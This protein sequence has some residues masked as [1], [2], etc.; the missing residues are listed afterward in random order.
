MLTIDK[1]LTE[2]VERGGS[3]LHIR[4]DSH[5]LV[6]I[7]G[8]LV[9]MEDVV[10]LSAGEAKKLCYSAVAEPL[11][12]RFEEEWEL[13]FAYSI[14]GVARFR[15]NLFVQ[16]G[17]VQSVFRVIPLRIQTLEE[18][19]LPPVC[20][21]FAERPRGLVLV[22]GPA[23]SGKSTTQAAMIDYI[24]DNFP[25]H[26]VTIEDPVEFIHEDREALINQRELDTDTRSFK[27]AL[28]A[29]LRQDPDV[30]LVGEM[31][32]L[33]TIQL[34]ITAA[35]TGH[36]VFGTLHTTDAVQ[37]I[38]RVIDVFPMH[39][40]QQIRM[41][42]SVN[43]VGVISQTLIK[44]REGNSRVAAFEILVGVPA[45]RNLIRESKTYQLGS[46]VQ[47]G[48]KQ[49]MMTLDQS[50]ATL[51]RNGTV[52]EEDAL[53]KS[54]NPAEFRYLVTGQQARPSTGDGAG[55]GVGDGHKPMVD[56]AAKDDELIDVPPARPEDQGHGL[57]IGGF[58]LPF[59]KKQ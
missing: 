20:R 36:L 30:I 10:P 17:L 48:T 4:A 6:R 13:D 11:Q 34:A 45:V 33:E 28:R 8:D 46:L 32:D 24:N 26:V 31:R 43:L 42:L 22:T 50:L 35:E 19:N 38:D 54:Q 21:F 39:Q 52:S 53:A 49:G 9:P 1:L 29:V 59:G 41:Q 14:E 58:R 55:H 47:T 18:L 16:R 23:G 40:Q 27:N 5:P 3:D 37:T 7:R 57:N 56:I 15:G 2:T 44:T 25:L 51:V 12:R